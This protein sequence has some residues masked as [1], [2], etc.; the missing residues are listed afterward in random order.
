MESFNSGPKKTKPMTDDELSTVL[1]RWEAVH[2]PSSLE[3]RVFGKAKHTES[4]WSGR[5]RPVDVPFPVAV[6]TVAMLVSVSVWG[7]VLER[8]LLRATTAHIAA[9]APNPADSLFRDEPPLT[10]S[11]SPIAESSAISSGSANHSGGSATPVPEDRIKV[12]RDVQQKSAAQDRG[13][14]YTRAEYTAYNAAHSE[15]NPQN[16]IKL[17]DDFVAKYPD[18]SLLP[19]AYEDYYR[20]YNAQGNYPKTIEYADKLVALGDRVELSLRLTALVTRSEAYLR[21]CGDRTLQVPEAYTK[22]RDAAAQGLQTLD[23]WPRPEAMTE[24]TFIAQKE[25]LIMLFD[26]ERRIAESSQGGDDGKA[27]KA[28]LPF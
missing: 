19:Y 14:T 6:M 17:L 27:C 12:P 1:H 5:R 10:L 22:A 4:G 21:G 2:A 9:K 18:S 24:E 13:P 26:S 16:K 11:R 20:S 23:R 15:A 8:K 28:L 7:V 3:A 25:R